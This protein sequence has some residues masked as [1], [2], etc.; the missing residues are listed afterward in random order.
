MDRSIL[1]VFL[2][3]IL[4][5]SHLSRCLL[6]SVYC[7]LVSVASLVVLPAPPSH[8]HCCYLACEAAAD[9]WST[10]TVHT[11]VLHAAG[12]LLLLAYLTSAMVWRGNGVIYMGCLR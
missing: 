2:A 12:L 6:I 9:V 11:N 5:I 3:T 10:Q 1:L 8:S 7:R 4:M